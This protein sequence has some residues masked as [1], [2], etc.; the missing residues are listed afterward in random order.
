MTPPKNDSTLRIYLQSSSVKKV[1]NWSWTDYLSS[2]PT[3]DL[4]PDRIYILCTN[5]WPP[6]RTDGLFPNIISILRTNYY[7]FSR[8][9]KTYVCFSLVETEII[10]SYGAGTTHWHRCCPSYYP[11][12]S[13]FAP[14]GPAS[15]CT[16]SR[17]LLVTPVIRRRTFLCLH[18]YPAPEVWGLVRII[19]I[20]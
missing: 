17:A 2:V 18:A 9:I 5:R 3:D 20:N 12:I 4:F 15:S 13:Q 10:F 14:T 19:A 8:A 16:K 6:F 1:M 7:E 11:G